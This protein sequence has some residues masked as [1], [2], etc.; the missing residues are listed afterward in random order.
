MHRV[1]AL[2]AFQLNQDGSLAHN[3]T[4]GLKGNALSLAKYEHK[5]S[6]IV[7]VDNIHESYST[8]K[9]RPAIAES[10][11]L[12]QSFSIKLRGV[13]VVWEEDIEYVQQLSVINRQGSFEESEARLDQVH[14]LLYTVENLRKRG[15]ES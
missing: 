6:M 8:T 11:V 2:F 7:S 4:L 13:V 12:L 10:S 1:P 5:A 3:Q 14:G 15:I 9:K